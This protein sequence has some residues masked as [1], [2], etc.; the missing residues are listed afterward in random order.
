MS[1]RYLSGRIRQLYQRPMPI[2]VVATLFVVLV[3]VSLVALDV[4]RAM[5]TR[6]IELHE[7]EIVASNLA[8]SL[9]QH[10]EDVI[11]N[12][13]STLVGLVERLEVEGIGSAERAR[14][15]SLL[16]N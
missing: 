3:C 2:M 10:V 11:S 16:S 12:A 4:G 9:G 7:S 13:D 6:A 1:L 8:R 14:L 5:Q 15:Y